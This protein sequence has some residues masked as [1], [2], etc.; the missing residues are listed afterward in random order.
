MSKFY[1]DVQDDAGV[2]SDIEGTEMPDVSTARS[3]ALRALGEMARDSL[4]TRVDGHEINIT[5]RAADR[6]PIFEL[7]LALSVRNLS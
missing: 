4:P 5:V 2:S 1:F 6:E 7:R 3:E